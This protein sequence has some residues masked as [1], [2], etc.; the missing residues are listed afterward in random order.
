MVSEALRRSF[1]DFQLSCTSH[2]P[3]IW[4]METLARSSQVDISLL[5]DLVEKTQE[6]SDDLSRNTREIVSLRILENVVF[7]RASTSPISST[8]CSKIDLNPSER[9]EDVLRKI[10]LETSASNLLSSGPDRLKWNL[11]SFLVQKRASFTK[12]ALQQLKVSILKGSHPVVASL[13]K[14]SDLQ[15]GDPPEHG[16]SIDDV[17][18][19]IVPTHEGS[20]AHTQYGAA[21]VLSN[22]PAL[23]HEN[24]LLHRNAPIEH[25]LLASRNGSG[26]F[27]DAGGKFCH[28][29]MAMN[30]GCETCLKGAKKYKHDE[31]TG[32]RQ[33]SKAHSCPLEKIDYVGCMGKNRLST[34]NECGPSK[35]L[36]GDNEV[37]RVVPNDKA[38]EEQERHSINET[39]G[40]NKGIL[41]LKT[42]NQ[43]MYTDE[44]TN[45]INVSNCGAPEEDFDHFCDSG[46]S[47]GRT[48]ITIRR[49]AFLSSQ[50]TYSQDSFATSDCRE[51]KL[52]VKCN[53]G[54]KLLVCSSTSCPLA[55]HVHCLGSAM[56]SDTV[57]SFYCPSCAYSRAIKQYEE[58]K[59]KTS[60]ALKGLIAFYCFGACRESKKQLVTSNQIE[61][62]EV[63]EENNEVIHRNFLEG[64]KNCQSKK[65]VED[66][67]AEPSALNSGDSLPSQGK[68]IESTNEMLLTMDELDHGVKKMAQDYQYPQDR[69]KNHMDA[70]VVYQLPHE[71]LSGQDPERSDRCDRYMKIRSKK[72][73]LCPKTESSRKR[74]CSLSIKSIDA[75]E[76]FDKENESACASKYF[77]SSPPSIH[78]SRRMRRPWTSAEEETLK[79]SAQM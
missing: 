60:S 69:G 36:V 33:Y 9:C 4:V 45:N 79:F 12:F 44:Q 72:G 22:S 55:V 17:N 43:A 40:E 14:H 29:E 51:V 78:L 26:T 77:V 71:N 48:D 66:K 5:L 41:E 15:V 70:L 76:M 39:E 62:D 73:G 54:G 58:A 3:W 1:M 65:N 59:E 38:D 11:E 64:R 32:I 34:D 49:N 35:G 25:L 50:C 21:N 30:N 37:L 57:E 75:E 8:S 56:K 28:D 61:L 74:T 18:C 2:L 10:L 63:V 16:V 42:T 52:C 46:Y 13:K 67:L 24:G 31:S 47:E 19:G 27:K 68:P 20:E 7:R 23:P 53:K 6:L